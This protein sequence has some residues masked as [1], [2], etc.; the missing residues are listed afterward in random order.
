MAFIF[1]VD[2]LNNLVTGSGGQKD[3]LEY[4]PHPDRLFMALVATAAKTRVYDAGAEEYVPKLQYPLYRRA[5]EWLESQEP[6]AIYA[7]PELLDSGV[8][9]TFVPVNYK[10]GNAGNKIVLP[11]YDPGARYRVPR[12]RPIGII[13]RPLFYAWQSDP[14]GDIREA[15]ADLAKDV[16]YLGTTWSSV[17]VRVVAEI[18]EPYR[19]GPCL[20]PLKQTG[21]PYGGQLALQSLRVPAPG[22]IDDLDREYRRV[23]AFL[24]DTSMKPSEAREISMRTFIGAPL[25]RYMWD[26]PVKGDGNAFARTAVARFRVRPSLPITWSGL[27]AEAVHA[28]L[29][30]AVTSLGKRFPHTDIEGYATG[31]GC[32]KELPHTFFVPLANVGFRYSDGTIKGFALLFPAS[33]GISRENVEAIYDAFIS[34]LAPQ[35]ELYL[36][37]GRVKNTG[38]VWPGARRIS[39]LVE[40]LE[41]QP[42][43]RYVFGDDGRSFHPEAKGGEH[44]RQ[45]ANVAGP[46]TLEWWRW[47]KNSH[48]WA[49]V[50]PV[51]LPRFPKKNLSVLQIVNDQLEILGLPPARRV[52]YR[53]LGALKGTPSVHEFRA[54]GTRYFENVWMHLILEFAE[55]V[56][57]PV[58]LGRGM[59]FGYGLLAPMPA[60]EDEKFGRDADSAASAENP[61]LEDVDAKQPFQNS[62]CLV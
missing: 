32:F 44:Y 21:T 26:Q 28:S 55:P 7:P 3:K 50:T 14:E 27:L 13:D 34:F 18:E 11:P 41:E 16:P 31:K 29:A 10:I 5:L 4:P 30:S 57:G 56:R 47:C 24:R 40:P 53:S 60:G 51:I 46:M 45:K 37:F 15:L 20:R 12:Q 35:N 8:L 17:A 33:E 1:R 6:P 59:Y 54:F 19:N 42:Y 38:T 52:T 49:S 22:R 39:F 2:Y 62:Q 25:A 58:L 36:D 23:I 48:V 9:H 61:G 43:F